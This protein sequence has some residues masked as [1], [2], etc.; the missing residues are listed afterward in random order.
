MKKYFAAM[1]GNQ[2]QVPVPLTGGQVFFRLFP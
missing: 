2:N 1:V